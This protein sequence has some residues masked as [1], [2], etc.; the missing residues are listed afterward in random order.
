MSYEKLKNMDERYA[1]LSKKLN[2]LQN[3]LNLLDSIRVS[4][5]FYDYLISELEKNESGIYIDFVNLIKSISNLKTLSWS[6]SLHKFNYPTSLDTLIIGNELGYFEG[7]TLRTPIS[8]F[9]K[10]D[11]FNEI[12]KKYDEFHN[13]ILS[14]IRKL[15]NKIQTLRS[16]FFKYDDKLEEQLIE[17]FS[18]SE[19][20]I[21]IMPDN[22]FEIIEIE[23][24]ERWFA[25]SEQLSD[26]RKIQRDYG[27][28]VCKIKK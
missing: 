25:N 14:N 27:E 13:N 6:I 11:D 7:T 20:E 15:D 18:K 22:M 4:D 2:N 3:K 16:E 21:I 5:D 1:K 8:Y 24:S 12:Y 23:K 19:V 10:Q 28:L 26:I 9:I 17:R